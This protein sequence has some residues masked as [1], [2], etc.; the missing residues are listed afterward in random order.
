MSNEQ[1]TH[2]I[3]TPNA[4][5]P[6]TIES[7]KL[8]LKKQY[9]T[10]ITNLLGGDDKKAL[11]FMSAGVYVLQKV[12]KLLECDPATLVQSLMSCAEFDL[13]P[14]N[15]AGEAFIIPYNGVA[16]F[17]LG[18]QGLITLLARG[19]YSV[20]AQIVRA[21]DK[22]EYAE[23][24]APVL[25]HSWPPF[26]SDA[27]RGE[28]VGVYAVITD[29]RGKVVSLTVMSREDVMK[30]KNLSKAK[31]S[32]YGPWNSNQDPFFTMW[33]KSAIKQATKF[34]PKTETLQKAIERDNE[35]DST[36]PKNTLNAEGPAAGAAS[37]KAELP[38]KAAPAASE[39]VTIHPITD[40]EAQTE[41]QKELEK[42][43]KAGEKK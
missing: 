35:E 34:V 24:L 16:Q 22:F 12:P 37:H 19:G 3:T 31:G 42:E 32:Q 11:R 28:P 41:L 43:G 17:Q 40:D 5:V 14:S 26:A 13:Y 21:K 6:L 20:N 7:F 1:P 18:Y 15:V 10:Q 39:D 9:L 38:A 36:I 27:D 29:V 23:G 30:I 8:T 25:N 4:R 2:A 33:K